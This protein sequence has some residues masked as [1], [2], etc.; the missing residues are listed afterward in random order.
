M[1]SGWDLT[2]PERVARLRAARDFVLGIPDREFYISHWWLSD[3][4]AFDE[5]RNRLFRVRDN[6]CGCPVGHMCEKRLFGLSPSTYKNNRERVFVI[7]G[8]AFAVPYKLAE[9]MFSEYTYP[10]NIGPP[11]KELVARRI[12]YVAS[13]MEASIKNSLS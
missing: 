9:F 7:V 10:S 5:E 4:Q 2:P 1:K 11:T 12:E 6:A 13:E 8:D 3:G